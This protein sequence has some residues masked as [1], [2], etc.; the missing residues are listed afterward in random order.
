MFTWLRVLS[1]RIA[2]FFFQRRIDHEFERE[3]Q[4]HLQLLAE[5]NQR[6]G[7]PP[8]EAWRAARVRLGG[9]SQLQESHRERRGLPAAGMLACDLRYAI[10]ALRKT[11]G[12]TSVAILSLALGIGANTA[13]FTL[14]QDLLLK[15]LPV[16]DPQQLVVVGSDRR[17][18]PFL[19]CYKTYVELRDRNTVF[20]GLIARDFYEFYVGAGGQTEAVNVELVSGN[21]FDVLGVPAVIGRTI[22]PEDDA[23][24]GAHAVAVLSYDFWTSRFGADRGVIGR[25][26][27]IQGHPFIVIGVSPASFRGINAGMAQSIRVPWAMAAVLKPAS[28][29]WNPFDEVGPDL[30]HAEMYHLFGRLKPG[31]SLRQAQASLEPLF[32]GIRQDHAGALLWDGAH[33]AGTQADRRRFLDRRILLGPVGSGFAGLKTTFRQPLLVLMGL[34]GILLLISCST[35][36]NLLLART[37]ARQKEIAIRLAIGASRSRVIWQVLTESLLLAGVSGGLGLLLAWRG[38]SAL[39]AA[40]GPNAAP[41]FSRTLIAL[42]VGPGPAILAFAL[43]LSLF[44]G[45]LSGLS[46]S[47]H[48]SRTTLTEAMKGGAAAFSGAWTHLRLRKVLI[49]V[50]VAL[51]LVLL[52]GAGLF[53][54]TLQSL[55]AGGTGLDQARLI[56]IEIDPDPYKRLGLAGKQRYYQDLLERIGKLPAVRS[57]ARSMTLLMTNDAYVWKANIEGREPRPGENLSVTWNAVSSRFFETAGIPLLAGRVW[58]PRDD[59]RSTREAVVSQAFA[60]YF[61]GERNPIGHLLTWRGGRKYEIV[62]EVGDARYGNLHSDDPR[63]V[64]LSPG[65]FDNVNNVLVRGAVDPSRLVAA[66]ERAAR[67]VNRDAYIHG[68]K[69][70]EQQ[71]DELLV[72][73]R[74]VAWLAGIFGLFGALLAASGLYGVIAYSVERRKREIGIRVALGGERKHILWLVFR[75]MLLLVGIGTAVGIPSAMALFGLVRSLLFGV[76][77]LDWPSLAGA[78]LLMCVVAAGAS[79][80]PARVAAG[81]DP[82]VAMRCE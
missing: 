43:G 4:A 32:A 57:T 40:M 75:E 28:G 77:P 33:G 71:I 15:W 48:T 78:A 20:S 37:Q 10:R 81:V 56:Q 36:A 3:I 62:G 79:Y 50:Q 26:I 39:V 59:E 25:T 45:L 74:L 31:V 34:V 14:I 76:T 42:N 55:K 16:K 24:R 65:E 19:Y 12:F 13:I 52:T 17:S 69:T 51:C 46:S 60:R 61:F 47:L 54:Q 35:V 23:V 82:M 38:A 29:G 8:E 73:E 41:G 58:T 22:S 53:V 30:Q 70:L 27:H 11:P 2:G 49:V 7:M 72:R 44:T 18:G 68:A 67:N 21:Y 63:C 1:S 6:R 64:Y 5:E 66:V 9:V 80:L